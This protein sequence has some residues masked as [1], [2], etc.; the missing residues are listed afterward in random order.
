MVNVIVGYEDETLQHNLQSV[1]L[2]RF[3]LITTLLF[4]INP[5]WNDSIYDLSP[6][7]VWGRG[8]IYEKAGRF[9]F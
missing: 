6:Q 8:F 7:T 3:S 5:K 1:L 2:Q 4:T 9:Y